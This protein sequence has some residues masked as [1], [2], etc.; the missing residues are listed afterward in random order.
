VLSQG[1]NRVDQ[2]I[3]AWTRALG[4]MPAENLT[5]A[6]KNQRDQYKSELATT[7]LKFE[8]LKANP[9]KVKGTAT[10]RG[11]DREKLPWKRAATMMPNLIA[12]QTWDS[13]VRRGCTCSPLDVILTL[14]S[15]CV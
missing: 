6:E 15:G 1:L 14:S 11:S 9:K 2:A 13:S 12:S 8:D 3:D 10:V 7:K 4:A 5:T